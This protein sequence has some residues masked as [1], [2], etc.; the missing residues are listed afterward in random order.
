MET[1]KPHQLNQAQQHVF[2]DSRLAPFVSAN[3]DAVVHE[4]RQ[5]D[6]RLDKVQHTWQRNE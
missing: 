2:I 3:F 6:L 5:L 4:L 1:R